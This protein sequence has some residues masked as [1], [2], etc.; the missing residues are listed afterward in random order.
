MIPQILLTL[1]L[2][3]LSY[4]ALTLGNN[5][6]RARAMKVPL[7]RIP[8]SPLN[9]FWIVIAPLVFWILDRLPFPDGNFNRYARYGWHF[10]DKAASHVQMGD[11]WAIVTPRETL[12]HICNAEAIN[13]IFA[14]RPDFVRPV[15]MYSQRDSVSY[16]TYQTR[17]T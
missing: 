16:F 12:L 10:R 8:V 6:R 3:W 1:G 2:A 5:Y 15:Q 14:R 11:A 9:T 13:D 17:L 4:S 7:I